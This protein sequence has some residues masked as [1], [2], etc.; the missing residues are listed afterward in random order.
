MAQD[1]RESSGT[2]VTNIDVARKERLDKS[3]VPYGRRQ[4]DDPGGPNLSAQLDD[5]AL[6][7]SVRPVR[8]GRTVGRSFDREKVE[9]IKAQLAHGEYKIDALKVADMFI[10]HERHN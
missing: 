9:K 6:R 8:E 3:T 4:T 10:E 7:P 5:L 1:T 2:R